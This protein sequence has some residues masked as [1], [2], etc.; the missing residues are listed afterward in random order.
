MLAPAFA[1]PIFWSSIAAIRSGAAHM[2]LPICARPLRP[3]RRPTSTFESSYALIHAECFISALRIMG[4]ASIP[5]WISSPVRSRKPV[6]MNTTRSFAARRHSR[7]LSV[8][9][10]SS[11]MMPILSVA[12]GSSKASSTRAKSAS[13]HATS[14]GPCIFGFTT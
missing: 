3:Q 4:P 10:R 1:C 14:S 9:R 13:A 6:L 11:S 7:R 2:P 12:R 5:V 8:V